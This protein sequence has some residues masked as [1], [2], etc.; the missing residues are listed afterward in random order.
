VPDGVTVMGS[1]A[2]SAKQFRTERAK[3]KSVLNG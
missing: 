1:P 2:V 3:L